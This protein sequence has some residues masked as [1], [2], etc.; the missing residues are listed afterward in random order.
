MRVEKDAGRA[1]QPSEESIFLLLKVKSCKSGE[2]G[3]GKISGRVDQHARFG[4]RFTA[5]W[6]G[7]QLIHF[8]LNESE[9]HTE[10]MR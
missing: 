4:V 5:G 9:R 10:V 7:G 8:H 3:R 1:V 2:C 6:G